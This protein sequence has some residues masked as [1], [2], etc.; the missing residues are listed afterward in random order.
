MAESDSDMSWECSKR[1][2]YCEDRGADSNP[3]H[4]ISFA[5]NNIDFLGKM[6]F[7]HL[8]QYCKSKTSVD[9][10]GA[11][12]ASAN[13]TSMKYKFGFQVPKEIKNAIE[14]DNKNGNSLYQDAVKTELK[15]LT[16]YQTFIVLDS[17]EDIP[18]GYQ[19]IPYHMVF[20]VKYDLIHTKTHR[21]GIIW[22]SNY[23]WQG[24]PII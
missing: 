1:L 6:P 2:K 22:R 21:E 17:G 15:Q 4:I 14:L 7:C 18:N 20:G 9:N 8:I 24:L 10:A 16:D 11:L 19:K 12:K 13:P 5:R 3:T 23:A